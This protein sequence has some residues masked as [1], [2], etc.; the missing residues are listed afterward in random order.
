MITPAPDAL[1]AGHEVPLSVTVARGNFY[2][3]RETCDACL[4]GIESVALLEREGQVLIVPLTP[5]SG[6]G[7]LLKIRN[8]RG[9][10][11]IHAQEFFRQKGYLEDFQERSFPAQWNAESAALVIASIPKGSL[12]VQTKFSS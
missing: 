5:Q 10:R 8:A 2:L 4:S 11:V 12:D 7:L 1:I 3:S 6:G 9:D